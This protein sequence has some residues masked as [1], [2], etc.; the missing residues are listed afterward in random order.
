VGTANVLRGQVKEGRA[1]LGPL[2]VSVPAH[3][4]DGSSVHAIV[5]PHDVRISKS[6]TPG[7]RA[8]GHIRRLARLGAYVKI[9]LDVATGEQVTVQLDRREFDAMALAEGDAVV[10]DLDEAR[11]F[12]EDYAI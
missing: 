12:V 5:R 4:P 8:V 1:A 2:A 11:I 7:P 3:V 9:D 6:E 10:I